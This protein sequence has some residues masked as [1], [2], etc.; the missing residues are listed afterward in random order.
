MI[1]ELIFAAR[2]LRRNPI[3][4]L[5]AA[6]TMALGIGA[7]TAIFSVTNA[8]LLRPLPYKDPDR[9]VVLYADLRARNNLGMPV[10]AENYTDFRNGS[11]AAFEDIAGM[12][13]GGR[14]VLAREDGTPEEVRFG[15]VTTNFFRVIGATIILGRDFEEADGTPPPS[16]GGGSTRA[17][18]PTSDAGHSE[19]RVLAPTL[20]RRSSGDRTG[21]AVGRCAPSTDRRR[22]GAAFPDHV[23]AGGQHGDDAGC[24]D[25]AASH[26]RQREPQYLLLAT[27]RSPEA[28]CDAVACPGRDR[29]GRRGYSQELLALRHGATL[30]AG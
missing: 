8:V 12:S 10:S 5:T 25:G 22:S 7:S 6:S 4:T 18:A 30:R 3:V 11:K 1:R 17:S 13:I 9:L 14:A 26:L 21:P 28:G 2:A 24:V 29:I 20:R 23:S 16:A 27:D 19:L 15:R